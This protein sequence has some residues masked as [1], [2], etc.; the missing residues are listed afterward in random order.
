[1]GLNKYYKTF[2][3]KFRKR[4]FL[5]KIPFDSNNFV[6]IS[7]YNEIISRKHGGKTNKRKNRKSKR[8]ISRKTIKKRS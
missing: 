7:N 4:I 3:T 6:N 5:G 2:A 1:M 8:K